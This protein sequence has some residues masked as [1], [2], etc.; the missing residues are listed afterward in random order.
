MQCFDP[1]WELEQAHV[2]IIDSKEDEPHLKKDDNEHRQFEFMG[3][4]DAATGL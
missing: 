1:W 4:F 3:C 2:L